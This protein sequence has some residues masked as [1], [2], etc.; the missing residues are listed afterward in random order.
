MGNIISNENG[1]KNKFIQMLIIILQTIKRDQDK[2][3]ITYKI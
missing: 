3:V 2:H 1:T